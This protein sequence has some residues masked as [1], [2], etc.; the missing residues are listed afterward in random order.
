MIKESHRKALAVKH[1]YQK[2]APHIE[3]NHYR[4]AS[5]YIKGLQHG[6]I[7]EIHSLENELEKQYQ[8]SNKFEHKEQAERHYIQW[9]SILMGV[10]EALEKELAAWGKFTTHK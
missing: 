7:Q 2:Q 4:N 5:R 1:I 10:H 9:R 8:Y 6:I 3:A